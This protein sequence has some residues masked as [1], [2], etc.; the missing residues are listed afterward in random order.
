MM[1]HNKHDQY[2]RRAGKESIIN[3]LWIGYCYFHLGEYKEALKEYEKITDQKFAHDNNS[4]ESNDHSTFQPSQIWVYIA[5]CQFYLGMYKEAE[6]NA[7]KAHNKSPSPLLNRL[8]F[9]LSHKLNDEKTLIQHHQQ[10]QVSHF[11]VKL[12]VN[13]F[14]LEVYC[15]YF[16]FLFEKQLFSGCNTRST[17]SRF[18]SLSSF[19]LSRSH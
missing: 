13:P 12:I 5:C 10:L 17:L 9:H 2:N 11:N 16:F 1:M 6:E 4:S 14:I 8:Q 18:D 19:T 3:D 7:N 15:N